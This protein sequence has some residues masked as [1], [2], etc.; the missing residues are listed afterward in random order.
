MIKNV[1]SSVL[2]D[3]NMQNIQVVPFHVCYETVKRRERET[4]TD[5]QRGGGR[6][7]CASVSAV[8]PADTTPRVSLK[9]KAA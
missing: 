8:W 6:E 9:Q 2:R 7:N 4:E 5:R 1:I 3:C